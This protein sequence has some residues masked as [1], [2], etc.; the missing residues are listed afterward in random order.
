MLRNPQLIKGGSFKDERGTVSFINDFTFYGVKRF[1]QINNANTDL[2]RAWQGHQVEHKYFYVS[3]GSF[4]IAWVKIDD[5][6]SPSVTLEGAHA[7]LR[8]NEPVILSIPPGYA[9]GILAL[10]KDASLI[11]FSDQTVASSTNDR[12]IYDQ[13]LWFNWQ[14]FK[15]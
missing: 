10:E 9:N 4:V 14:Q 13:K 11:I 3:T 12:W 1:Y 15:I 8:A 5:W 2:V 7:T 6:Q